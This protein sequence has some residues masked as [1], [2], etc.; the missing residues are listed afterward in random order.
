MGE[1][2]IEPF[3]AIAFIRAH[4][5]GFTETGSPAALTGGAITDNL[6]VSTLGARFQTRSGPFTLRGSTGWRV[7]SGDKDFGSVLS[8]AGGTPSLVRPGS[9][10]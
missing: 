8:F 6:T 3:G 4:T 5:N 9:A 10:S 2:Y 7:A 1:G